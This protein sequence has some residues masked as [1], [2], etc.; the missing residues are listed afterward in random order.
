M[1]ALYTLFIFTLAVAEMQ[2]S[3]LDLQLIC[4]I[5]LIRYGS[6]RMFL[7]FLCLLSASTICS[8][9][10]CSDQGRGRFSSTAAHNPPTTHL[11]L[12][13]RVPGEGLDL[14]CH[15]RISRNIWVCCKAGSSLFLLCLSFHVLYLS[16]LSLSIFQPI[17]EPAWNRS[18]NSD[19]KSQSIFPIPHLEFWRGFPKCGVYR[20]M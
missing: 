15:V 13:W 11:I 5:N 3:Q 8:N 10:I 4:F 19:I 17:L 12:I 20:V 9:A 18:L 1:D 7:C 6:S 2:G 16:F 14:H